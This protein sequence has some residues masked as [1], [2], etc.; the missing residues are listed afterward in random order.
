M[1][2]SA[3]SKHSTYMCPYQLPKPYIH[4]HRI[5]KPKMYYKNVKYKAIE[6]KTKH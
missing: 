3:L 5:N 6:E 1:L 4:K 2:S